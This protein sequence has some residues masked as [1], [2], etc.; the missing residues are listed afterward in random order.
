MYTITY[1]NHNVTS[2]PP[3]LQVHQMS[4]A[5][6]IN[7]SRTQCAKYTTDCILKISILLSYSY[8]KL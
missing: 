5:H 4:L 6:K 2:V 7:K 3:S 1:L 8:Q